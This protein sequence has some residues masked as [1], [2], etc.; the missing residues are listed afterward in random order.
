MYAQVEKSKESKGRAVRNL[1]IQNKV[2]SQSTLQ[3]LD[4]TPNIGIS[5]K[6]NSAKPTTQL[7]QL[8]CKVCEEE[9]E[10][11]LKKQARVIQRAPCTV[12]NHYP[13]DADHKRVQDFIISRNAGFD[14]EYEVAAG[15]TC[16]GGV[17]YVDLVNKARDRVYEVKPRGQS[18]AAAAEAA[19]YAGQMQHCGC[20]SAAAP[21][22]LSHNY[23]RDLGVDGNGNA[24]KLC[25]KMLGAGGAVTYE[26]QQAA[27][28]NFT[29]VW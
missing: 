1:T 11:Q 16:N 13:G 6:M 3:F 21:G 4:N 15:A 5:V 26:V 28:C 14:K 22:G 23:T 19:Y 20:N 8:K 17:Q 2:K 27:A 25:I 7:A 10:V 24:E 12:S 9:E 18:V 29:G